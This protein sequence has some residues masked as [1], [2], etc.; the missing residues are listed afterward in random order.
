MA[1]AIKPILI[2]MGI[3][4]IVQAAIFTMVM[5]MIVMEISVPLIT[6]LLWE[7]RL[8]ILH[9]VFRESVICMGEKHFRTM[10]VIVT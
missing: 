7:D 4:V 8:Q 1:T 10:K 5:A 6:R 9:P 2:I 3:M